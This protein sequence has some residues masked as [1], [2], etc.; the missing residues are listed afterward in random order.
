MAASTTSS[1]LPSAYTALKAF[2][3][4]P[5]LGVGSVLMLDVLGLA[6]MPA[7]LRGSHTRPDMADKWAAGAKLLGVP[8]LAFTAFLGVSKLAFAA[9]FWA[10]RGAFPISERNGVAL[11][12]VMYAGAAAGHY[13]LDGDVVG[14]LVM[15]ALAALQY[16]MLPAADEGKGGKAK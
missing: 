11:S 14:P 9:S 13:A 2:M 1:A 16:V 5:L 4:L 15:A 8:A 12:I 10:P 6:A 7:A 3:T